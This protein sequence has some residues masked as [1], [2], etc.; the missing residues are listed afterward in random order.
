[1]ELEEMIPTETD[2]REAALIIA[3]YEGLRSLRRI[4]AKLQADPSKDLMPY[5]PAQNLALY[6][7]FVESNWGKMLTEFQNQTI[8]TKN[9]WNILGG[10]DQNAISRAILLYNFDELITP[11]FEDAVMNDEVVTWEIVINKGTVK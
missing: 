5:N 6:I 11:V 3:I 7:L 4:L 2:L 1:M 9:G 8:D 10:I